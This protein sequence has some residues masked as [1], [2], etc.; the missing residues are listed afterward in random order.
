[1][2]SMGMLLADWSIELIKS[3]RKKKKEKKEKKCKEDI[4]ITRG[5]VCNSCKEKH[6]ELN[7]QNEKLKA[8]ATEQNQLESLLK[9]LE[10]LDINPEEI[11][12]MSLEAR[13]AQLVQ[14]AKEAREDLEKARG[15]CTQLAEGIGRQLSERDRAHSERIKSLEILMNEKEKQLLQTSNV[16]RQQLAAAK[17]ELQQLESK[18]TGLLRTVK[19]P[20]G[21]LEQEVESLRMVLEMRRVEVE[22]LRAA[23]NALMLEM[24]R[25][26]AMELHLQQQNQRV[27]EMDAVIQNKNL[28]IRKLYDDQERLSQQ[29]EIEESAH[30]ACQ[31][32]LEQSQ[33][34]LQNF[35]TT[36]QEKVTKN[37]QNL[38]ESGL[39]LDLVHKDK[40]VAYSINC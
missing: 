38:K 2:G 18:E 6:D 4:N 5:A 13:V 15:E 31:Q 21:S 16:L 39:I 20:E 25:C 40:S 28:E 33:W 12:D 1:M 36:N 26:R 30:L 32:E 10:P 7:H 8:Y 37:I 27:E 29:L 35:I 19:A 17:R 34:A 23:N 11:A 22:Q 9:S 3:R 24:D 14:Q